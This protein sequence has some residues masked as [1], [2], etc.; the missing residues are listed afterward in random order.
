MRARQAAM[1]WLLNLLQL[2]LNFALPRRCFGC[3]DIMGDGRGFCPMCWAGL[4]HL[5]IEGC[6]LCRAP[7]S[8]EGAV[9]AACLLQPP[10]HDGVLAALGYGEVARTLVLRL[11]YGRR[12]GC[13]SVMATLLEARARLFP[14]ALLVPVPLHRWRMWGRGFNQSQMIAA[15]IARQTGQTLYAEMLKRPKRTRPLGTLSR[16]AR[17]HEVKAAFAINPRFQSDLVGRDVLLVDDVYTSGATANSCAAVLK[18]AG[19][20]KVYVLCWARVLHAKEGV[21][22]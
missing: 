19:A 6:A 9:C 16:P 7:M 22:F 15:A 11:K 12:L 17:A 4:D 8:L 10:Q 1:A 3:G 18:K 5:P 14:D 21:D 13:A 20:A 2:P